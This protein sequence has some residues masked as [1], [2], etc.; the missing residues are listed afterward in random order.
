MY[1]SDNIEGNLLGKQRQLSQGLLAW[2][3]QALRN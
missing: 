2:I 1:C 3:V